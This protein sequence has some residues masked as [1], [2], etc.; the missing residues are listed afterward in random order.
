MRS[1]N[2]LA[3]TVFMAMMVTPSN[4]FGAKGAMGIHVLPG[5]SNAM[6]NRVVTEE[7]MKTLD[8]T[9]VFDKDHRVVVFHNPSS[10]KKGKTL[11]LDVPE[12]VDL[13]DAVVISCQEGR[14][15][16][17]TEKLIIRTLGSKD[18]AEG[19]EMLGVM[20]DGALH[21]QN[22]LFFVLVP[23]G[24]ISKAEVNGAEITVTNEENQRYRI[25]ADDPASKATEI[26]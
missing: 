6:L 11:K 16:I 7:A 12:D 21:P 18:V 3:I 8:A 19:R 14:T 4:C 15:V 22:A 23:L 2:A 5:K 25:N 10:D 20:D 13:T 17:V 1:K 9:C 26:E 24:K